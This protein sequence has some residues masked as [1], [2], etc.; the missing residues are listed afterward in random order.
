MK[1]ILVANRGEIAR[2]VFRTARAMGIETVAVYSEPD[3]DAPFIREADI[4]IP[5]R[6]ATSA[7]TYL[8]VEQIIDA[9]RRSGAD[10]V[11]PG[12]GFLS[13]NAGF[14]EAMG[15]AGV[16][17]IGPTP[18]SIRAMAL[19]VEAKRLAS[20]AGVPLVPGA[21]LGDG[22]DAAAVAAEV[23]YPL[24]VKASAGGGGKGMRIVER[25]EDLNDAL[26]SARREAQASFGDPTVFLERYLTESRHVEVQVFGD[27]HGNVVHLG[28]R[29]CSIQRRHQKIVEE[30]PS[31]GLAPHLAD[32]MYAAAVSLAS[33][34]GYVGA[35]TVEFIVAGEG[36]AQEFF[37]LEMNTRL[38]VEH[39]VT[40]MVTGIDLV[41]WQIRVARGERLPRTQSEI[42]P[43]GHAIEVRLYAEDPARGYLPNTGVL[44][45]FETP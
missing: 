9:V 26:E 23:G 10:A 12:Y 25:P 3:A 41:E 34:I 2:R 22:V 6:G 1:R 17:W 36:D 33:S 35:G 28:E 44:E 11:H 24:L 43:C 19:K 27:I 14:A 8:D 4:S 39:P 42:A 45:C 5:L 21:E 32:P 37:F 30:S 20:S 18:E 29:E 7:E 16:T 40:E 15:A 13:E 31:P 38:Q